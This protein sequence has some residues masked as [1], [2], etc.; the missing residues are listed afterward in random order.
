MSSGKLIRTRNATKNE[1]VIT[2]WLGERQRDYL[3]I[4]L[5]LLQDGDIDHAR[6]SLRLLM[7]LLKEQRLCASLDKNTSGSSSLLDKILESLISSRT[8]EELCMD[9]KERYVIQYADLRLYTFR[10]LR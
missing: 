1:K 6:L 2:Q 8:F 10:T 3:D 9:F 4:C 7:Q 5:N